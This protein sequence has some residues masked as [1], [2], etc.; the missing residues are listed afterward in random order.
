MKVHAKEELQGCKMNP[1]SVRVE[2]EVDTGAQ[3]NEHRLMAD[4]NKDKS[5][6][7]TTSANRESTV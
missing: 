3:D 6:P 5:V 2:K 1:P 4:G 7:R